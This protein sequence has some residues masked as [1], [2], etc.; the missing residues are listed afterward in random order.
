MGN[1]NVLEFRL[2]GWLENAG[3]CGLINIL[4]EENILLTSQSIK[5]SVNQLENFADHYFDFFAKNYRQLSSLTKIFSY[6]DQK[7]KFEQENF[8]NFGQKDYE[9]LATYL[10][11]VRQYGESNSY[12]AVYP[13]L[14]HSTDILTV[15]SSLKLERLKKD[16][17]EKE[18]GLIMEKVKVVYQR[19]DQV[20]EYFSDPQVNKYISGKIQI[21][22]VINKGYNNVAFLNRQQS[23]DDYYE[24]YYNFFIQPIFDYYEQD[25]QKDKLTCTNCGRPIKK[26]VPYSFLNQMGYDVNRKTS[27]S[28]NF[29]NDIW[30]CPQCRLLYSCIPAG[31]SYVYSQGIFVN[32]NH[33]VK[34]LLQV[35]RAI[36]T[37]ILDL[38]HLQVNS[39][40]T[41]AAMIQTLQLENLKQNERELNDIQVV[42]YENERYYFSLLSRIL[43][44]TLATSKADLEPLIKGGYNIAGEY[45]NLYQAV[46]SRLMNSTNLFSLLNLLQRQLL[47]GERTFVNSWYLMALIRINQNFL[48]ELIDMEKLTAEKLER[49]RKDGYLFKLGYEN[50]NKATSIGYRMLNALKAN[51]KDGYMD[52]LLNSY[53]YLGKI[54]PPYFNEIFLNDEH[55]KTIG[56]TFLTGLI[57]ESKGGNENG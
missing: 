20:Y 49:I 56:Y 27:N 19:L 47:S 29:V 51:D 8:A 48:E 4:G 30:M 9:F 13:L 5:L 57:G 7:E 44:K 55:F 26:G 43:L 52:V 23:K 37:R 21:Y 6:Q 3:V 38:N 31:F 39:T 53:M 42:R 12:K 41:Y 32:D 46:I 35:N 1:E 22:N 18:T 45:H 36:R 28:W 10:K 17:W 33:S 24:S 54:V 34:K 14:N 25:H 16:Q 50:K 15:L 40:N 2:N 11:S